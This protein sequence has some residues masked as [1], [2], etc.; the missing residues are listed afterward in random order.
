LTTSK[1]QGKLVSIIIVS[2]SIMQ[3]ESLCYFQLC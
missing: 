1:C 2:V 3:R